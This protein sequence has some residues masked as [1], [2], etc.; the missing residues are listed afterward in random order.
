MDT[1]RVKQ[2]TVGAMQENCYLLTDT[3]TQQGVVIDPGDDAE[4][5]CEHIQSSGMTPVAVAATHG[6]FDHIMAAGEIQRIYNIPFCMRGEDA[7][8]L[9]RMA[10]TAQHFLGHPIV[11]LQPVLSRK[12]AAPDEII[13]GN[14]KILVLP[15]PGHTPGSVMLYHKDSAAVFVGDAIFEGGSVGRTDFSY[16]DKTALSDSVRTILSLPGNTTVYSGHG[17]PTT[18]GELGV[19][20]T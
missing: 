19:Y 20:F 6:H 10:D 7:F 3:D 16:S 8:L 12:L 17:N 9:K 2:L 11:V 18:I 13:F 4:Y 5:I 15:I 1:L 14:N